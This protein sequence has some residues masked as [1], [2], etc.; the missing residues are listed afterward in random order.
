MCPAGGFLSGYLILLI[1]PRAPVQIPCIVFFLLSCPVVVD[2]T[3]ADLR[4][5]TGCDSAHALLQKRDVAAQEGLVVTTPEIC[6]EAILRVSSIRTQ[7]LFKGVARPS[8]AGRSVVLSEEDGYGTQ[9]S[10]SW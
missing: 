6:F 5:I 1:I 3:G 9:L 2:N 10:C 4:K 7:M 8:S